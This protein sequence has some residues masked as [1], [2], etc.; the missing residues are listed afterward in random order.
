MSKKRKRNNNLL[1]PLT[2][3]FIIKKIEISNSELADKRINKTCKVSNDFYN[4]ELLFKEIREVKDLVKKLFEMRFV[5]VYNSSHHNSFKTRPKPPSI[6]VKDD[7][8]IKKELINE[9]KQVLKKRG[10]AN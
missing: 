9:L 4:F 7:A 8:D 5:G 6:K 10:V 3:F 1:I 2:E